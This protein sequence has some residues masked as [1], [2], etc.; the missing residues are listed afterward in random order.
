MLHAG[1][2]QN[3]SPCPSVSRS[4]AILMEQGS[5][6]RETFCLQESHS[7][8]RKKC[9]YEPVQ[10][11]L[12]LHVLCSLCSASASLKSLMG[13]AQNCSR[14]PP[15]RL[16]SQHPRIQLA[17]FQ[18]EGGLG[19]QADTHPLGIN[20]I[21]AATP[22]ARTAQMLPA[23]PGAGWHLRRPAT[24]RAQSRPQSSANPARQAARQP[25]TALKPKTRLLLNFPAKP[26]GPSVLNHSPSIRS[27]Y[28][29]PVSPTSMRLHTTRL[30]AQLSSDPKNQYCSNPRI[31]GQ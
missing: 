28:K 24:H 10:I 22:R 16:G 21:S 8:K 2:Q 30:P 20:D 12:L 4:P 17:L 18:T 14:L 11:V 29:A 19:K 15:P 6:N 31:R 13:L 3:G 7:L 25:E 27:H 9:I 5:E 26:P 23:A 1:T